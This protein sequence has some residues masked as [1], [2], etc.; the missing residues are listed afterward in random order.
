L[1]G[2]EHHFLGAIFHILATKIIEN[3]GFVNVNLKKK[4]LKK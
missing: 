4:M 1:V 3:F 2:G